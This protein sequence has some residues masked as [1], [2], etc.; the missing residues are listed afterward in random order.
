MY[1]VTLPHTA[2]ATHALGMRDRLKTKDFRPATTGPE[3]TL[4]IVGSLTM[5][6]DTS[7]TPHLCFLDNDH[8]DAPL[9]AP[10]DVL[11]RAGIKIGRFDGVI[12]DPA[13]R[14]VRY[15]VVDRGSLSHERCLIPLPSVCI[16]AEHHEMRL[17]I[18]DDDPSEWQHFDAANFPPFSDDDLLT[19]MF[20]RRC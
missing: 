1:R 14:R 15:L 17:D 9:V 20:A 6:N 7:A 18:D 5:T 12:V 13:E 4:A 10:L 19:A 3:L 8:L 11:S 2:T 16:D